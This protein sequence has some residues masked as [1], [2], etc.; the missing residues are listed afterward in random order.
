[1]NHSDY[2][3]YQ[4]RIITT[5]SRRLATR[6]G[7]S[8]DRVL[9]AINDLGCSDDFIRKHVR[10][11]TVELRMRKGKRVEHFVRLTKDGFSIVAAE[12][13]TKK[14][15]AISMAFLEA[16]DALAAELHDLRVDAGCQRTPPRRGSAGSSICEPF[17]L[18]PRLDGLLN[19]PAN[20]LNALDRFRASIGLPVP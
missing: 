15:A 7:Q 5:D 6:Y 3:Y 16:F 9:H 12:F 2:V 10:P 1:M 8:H 4:D 13:H 18:Y 17:D 11:V 20:R 14:T 19:P